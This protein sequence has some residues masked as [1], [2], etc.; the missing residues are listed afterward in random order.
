[1]DVYTVIANLAGVPAIAQSMAIRDGLPLGVQLIAGPLEEEKLVS[2]G[3]LV[4]EAT[5]LA[6]VVAG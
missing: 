3:L 1:M 4:E 5:G 2:L 6:G